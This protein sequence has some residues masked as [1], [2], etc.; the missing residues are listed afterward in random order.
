MLSLGVEVDRRR[1]DRLR[2]PQGDLAVP[3]G[4][5]LAGDRVRR[6][7]RPTSRV[8]ADFTAVGTQIAQSRSRSC[9]PEAS[10]HRARDLRGGAH[11]LRQRRLRLGVST[12]GQPGRRLHQA[13]QQRRP[14]RSAT[15]T[16]A[17]GNALFQWAPGPRLVE[18][19]ELHDRRTDQLHA[20]QRLL[21]P[22]RRARR[23]DV[24]GRD[25]SR[26]PAASPAP[27]PSSC[28]VGNT[29]T[30]PLASIVTLTPSKKN[31]VWNASTI[32]LRGTLASPLAR[33][34]GQKVYIQSKA[35]TVDDVEDHQV[36]HH[37]LDR[38][39]RR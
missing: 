14:P 1:R 9:A 17:G 36:A 21:H 29:W 8:A 3:A 20:R 6:G 15:T 34:K 39:V 2:E 10:G 16:D 25:R 11:H 30:G 7:D 28:T 4:A 23:R 5:V 26:S 12:H 33:L 13:G 32:T 22:R 35:P 18:D 38:H 19:R 27:T 31:V 37:E 24:S